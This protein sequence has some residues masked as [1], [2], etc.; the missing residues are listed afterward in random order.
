MRTAVSRLV[1]GSLFAAGCSLGTGEAPDPPTELAVG[2]WGGNNSGAI[3]TE[4]ELHVHFGCTLGDF[5]R[6]AALDSSGSFSLSGSYVLRAFPIQ[7]GP[8]LPAR[9]SGVVRGRV[10]TLSVAV[11]DTV[12]KKLVILGPATLTLGRD[13]RMGP[14]PICDARMFASRRLQ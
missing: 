4:T 7:L 5:K 8:S 3:V 1:L 2:A 11:D 6:P 12:E 14:C 13:A 9:V 10:M